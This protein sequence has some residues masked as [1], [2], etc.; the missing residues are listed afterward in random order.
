MLGEVQQAFGKRDEGQFRT[1]QVTAR[2]TPE[3]GLELIT[4]L[5]EKAR[6][7]E[8][9][10]LEPIVVTAFLHPPSELRGGGAS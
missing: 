10:S 9:L 5:V 2:I 6:D 8:D 4:E 1:A 7:M 3:Q